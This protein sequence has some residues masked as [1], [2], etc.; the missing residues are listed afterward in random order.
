MTTSDPVRPDDDGLKPTLTLLDSTMINVGTIIASG[1]FLVPAIIAA[2]FTAPG[3]ALLVWIAGA[4]VSLCGALS[5]AELGAAMP[6]AG[7]Q[8]VYLTRAFGPVWGYLYGWGSSVVV[9]PASIA[10][11]AV[12]FATYLAYFVPLGPWG[13]KLVAIASILALTLL[14]CFG[15]KLGAITQN[16]LTFI[17]LAGVFG[18][19]IAG[20][21]YAGGSVQNLQPFWPDEPIVSLIGPF[22]VAMVA[23]LWAFD[24]WIEITYVGSEL[25]RP[26][27]DMSRSIILST[28]L[29]G[30]IYALVA[31]ALTFVLGH[32]AVAA[33]ERVA[34]DAMTVVLGAAGATLI[35]ATILVS[36]LGA[37][38]GIVFTAARIPYAMARDGKFFAWAGTVS[39]RFNVPVTAIVV[40]G[41]WSASLVLLGTYEQLATYVVFVSFL[42]YALSCVAV[43][44]LRKREPDMPRP[45]RAWGYPVTPIVFVLFALYLVGN[46][47]VETPVESLI[48]GG[49]LGV[50]LVFYYALGWNVVGAGNRE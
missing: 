22:G 18:I 28:V 40:Q 1:I 23:V 20:L 48:G 29:V 6:K 38:N 2:K 19:V 15:L 39:P 16:V 30:V 44:V 27:R 4:L 41:L 9:N 42:F 33:S 5:V 37:N 3:P 47:I 43:L 17:K 31:V 8:F 46:A 45:Y 26:E 35:T 50:G 11:I 14:N 36:T 24:G 34:S 49:L 25:K 7:G 13:V 10:A 12:G 21:T 32:G